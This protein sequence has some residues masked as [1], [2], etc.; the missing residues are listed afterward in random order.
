ME[1]C[2]GIP[3]SSSSS[4][5]LG[6]SSFGFSGSGFFSGFFSRGLSS[7]AVRGPNIQLYYSKH[8]VVNPLM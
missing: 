8:K 4:F 5:S 6:L 7:S 1:S 2:G 3:S